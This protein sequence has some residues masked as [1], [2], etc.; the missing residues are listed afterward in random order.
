MRGGAWRARAVETEG[1]EPSET[2]TNI[3]KVKRTATQRSGFVQQEHW[4]S[5]SVYLVYD[6][7]G[8]S[9]WLRPAAGCTCSTAQRVSFAVWSHSGWSWRLNL[10]AIAIGGGGE[11]R[12][13]T[14]ARRLTCRGPREVPSCRLDSYEIR[15]CTRESTRASCTNEILRST[16][17]RSRCQLYNHR[18][19]IRFAGTIHA[20]AI[21]ET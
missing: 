16:Q 18:F 8:G 19:A 12:R 5:R 10:R 3:T 17:T 11:I 21:N 15:L 9:G 4:L 14:A 2:E 1:G 20:H 13:R 7:S 6:A